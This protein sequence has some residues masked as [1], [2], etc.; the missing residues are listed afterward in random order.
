MSLTRLIFSSSSASILCIYRNGIV[1][2][3]FVMCSTGAWAD[4]RV[5]QT[6]WPRRQTRTTAR[7]SVRYWPVGSSAV[8]FAVGGTGATRG[9]SPTTVPSTPKPNQTSLCYSLPHT[10][11]NLIHQCILCISV[12]YTSSTNYM[13][14]RV[15]FLQCVSIPIKSTWILQSYWCHLPISTTTSLNCF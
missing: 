2:Y 11:A 10:M 1:S 13:P 15:I 9:W 6:G 12:I 3:K 7:A 8:T 5:R 4:R 14:L